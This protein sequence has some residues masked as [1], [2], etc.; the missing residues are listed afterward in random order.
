MPNVS[1]AQNREDV[2][3]SRVF[4]GPAG[5]YLDVG[6]ADPVELSV[7]KWFYDRGWSGVN[8]EPQ[9]GYFAALS[10]ARPRDVNVNAVASDGPG[11]VTFYEFPDHPLLSTPDANLAAKYR[12]AGE[13]VVAR[14][15]PALT[16]AEICERHVRGPIDFLK[17]DVEGHEPAVLRGADF[18]R[19]RPVVLL[20]EATEAESPTPN[21]AA[22][23]HLVL[24]ADYRFAT[25]DGLNRFYVRAE[26][27]DRLVPRLRVPINLF[28]E[29]HVTADRW[30]EW[31]ERSA[32]QQAWASAR[33]GWERE[34]AELTDRV[35]WLEGQLRLY[36]A[37]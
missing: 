4:P 1:Y 14:A 33:A 32:E 21:H 31:A 23:E 20:V 24:A 7:T 29:Y 16:L 15:V 19:W 11:E 18:A 35:R 9:P 13:R 2:L 17:I 10:A 5:F 30:R 36:R 8:V 6:A 25:F 3:L 28:D 12:A 34:R 26:D 37:A 27:A 22:W